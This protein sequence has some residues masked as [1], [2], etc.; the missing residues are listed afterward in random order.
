M[1]SSKLSGRRSNAGTPRV[2]RA[3]VRHRCPPPAHSLDCDILPVGD[4]IPTNS[5]VDVDFWNDD[6]GLPDNDP[7]DYV[8][9]TASGGF[10]TP[11][12]PVDFLNRHAQQ[13]VWTSP[14]LPGDYLLTATY[15]WSDT[16][17]CHSEYSIH[18]DAP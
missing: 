13:L 10:W 17:S 16:H 4:P 2:T 7:L 15:W 3:S 8:H 1:V 5:P 6:T 12:P 11:E 18:V 14:A 9:I